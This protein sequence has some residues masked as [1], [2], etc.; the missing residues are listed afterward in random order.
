MDKGTFRLA[1]DHAT[2]GRHYDTVEC[3]VV[4]AI[5][6]SHAARHVGGIVKPLKKTLIIEIKCLASGMGGSLRW[7]DHAE[8]S[9]GLTIL[10]VSLY[11]FDLNAGLSQ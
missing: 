2:K 4:K 11:F 3:D 9:P 6:C 1:L 10:L 8:L 5:V 7:E